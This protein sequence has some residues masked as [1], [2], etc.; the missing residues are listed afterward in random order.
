MEI[1]PRQ[2]QTRSLLIRAPRRCRFPSHRQGGLHGYDDACDVGQR[3]AQV[4][5]ESENPS[6]ERTVQGCRT[7]K[8]PC[9]NVGIRMDALGYGSSRV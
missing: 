8:M 5:I 2:R 9:C 4:L 3:I 1:P 6:N 7:L